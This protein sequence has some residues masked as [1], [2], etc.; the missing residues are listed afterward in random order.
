MKTLDVMRRRAKRFTRRGF[1][2]GAAA[3]YLATESIS[4]FVVDPLLEDDSSIPD[5]FRRKRVIYE[6]QRM[7]RLDAIATAPMRE[8][9]EA[10]RMQSVGLS[11][12]ALTRATF[13]SIS[14]DGVRR[15]I[16]WQ[17]PRAGWILFEAHVAPGTLMIE[18]PDPELGASAEERL[19]RAAMTGE[20]RLDLVH[21]EPVGRAPILYYG[22]ALPYADGRV[23]SITTPADQES[24]ALVPSPPLAT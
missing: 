11:D 12:A 7:E 6:P 9:L 10:W 22:L 21:Y 14:A 19:T 1:L 5:A 3:G 20:P 2:I 13:T 4:Q 17:T 8:A 16:D 18:Q 23:I 24:D 15:Q